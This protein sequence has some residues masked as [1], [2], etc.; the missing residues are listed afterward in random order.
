[1]SNNTGENS[2]VTNTNA[3]KEPVLCVAC[4][5]FFGNAANEDMC[6]KCFKEKVK[7]KTETAPAP[8]ITAL[9]S[10]TRMEEEAKT[11]QVKAS[12]PKQEDTSKCWLCARKVGMLGYKCRCE[13][14]FCKNHRLPED[15]DCDFDFQ[16]REREKLQKAN[17]TVVA[18]KLK[19]I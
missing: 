11:E 6:S 8:A 1:M 7:T 4:G 13:Y 9:K 14:T 19:D 18:S 3:S 12:T 2:N 10:P 17:P 16:T 5:L 15:H